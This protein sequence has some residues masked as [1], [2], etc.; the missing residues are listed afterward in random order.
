RQEALG[1]AATLA[2]VAAARPEPPERAG[3]ARRRFRVP[4][5][6]EP[7]QG[8]AQVVVLGVQQVSGAGALGT[9]QRRTLRL[10]QEE[11]GVPLRDLLQLAALHQPLV[12]EG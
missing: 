12:P 9:H 2:D 7:A 5:L 3:H 6:G 11:A 10:L 4:L 8:A 1:P